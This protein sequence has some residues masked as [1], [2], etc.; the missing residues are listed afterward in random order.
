LGPTGSAA[1]GGVVTDT[2][3]AVIPNA[4]V[5][6]TNTATSQTF[7]TVT[8]STGLYAFQG[9]N[10]G[11]YRLEARA[12]GFQTYVH[13][14]ITVAPPE[15]VLA[16][17]ALQVGAETQTVSVEADSLAIETESSVVSGTI[18]GEKPANSHPAAF[19]LT[20]DIGQVW[21]SSD[22]RHWKRK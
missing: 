13:D 20:T 17:F 2:T 16:N 19:E 4:T 7:T 12:R 22:G 14:G 3:G 6:V 15:K 18:S 8:G 21:V 11:V 10:P 9:L 1:L 5:I